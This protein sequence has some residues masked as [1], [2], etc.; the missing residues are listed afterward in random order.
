MS[1]KTPGRSLYTVASLAGNVQ[2]NKLRDSASHVSHSYAGSCQPPLYSTPIAANLQATTTQR[3]K[4][5]RSCLCTRLGNSFFTTHAIVDFTSKLRL[6]CKSHLLVH[7]VLAEVHNS[8]FFLGDDSIPCMPH[9][10]KQVHGRCRRPIATD[11]GHCPL[12]RHE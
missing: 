7:M 10:G 5:H 8:E 6:F 4:P 1:L 11:L 2:C 9:P 3:T 12:R